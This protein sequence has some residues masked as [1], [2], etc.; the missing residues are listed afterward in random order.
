MIKRDYMIRC[1]RCN[2]PYKPE[3]VSRIRTCIYCRRSEISER[4]E[5]LKMLITDIKNYYYSHNIYPTS[6]IVRK[7]IS[8]KF[9]VSDGTIDS[10][11]KELEK[12]NVIKV[13]NGDYIDR[14][15]LLNVA[16]QPIN[17]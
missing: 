4:S 17:T 8:L 15:K 12:L 16:Q 6:E 3:N 2:I 5:R 11:F 13:V 9:E 1:K 14:V 10:Y 7:W